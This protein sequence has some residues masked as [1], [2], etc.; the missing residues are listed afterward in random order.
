M[1]YTN[2]TVCIIPLKLVQTADNKNT[3]YTSTSNGTGHHNTRVHFFG[4]VHFISERGKKPTIFP[5]CNTVAFPYLYCRN[6]NNHLTLKWN[7]PSQCTVHL[8]W[9]SSFHRRGGSNFYF[10]RDYESFTRHHNLIPKLFT[11]HKI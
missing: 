5:E 2:N 10:G 7:V 9:D 3:R 1:M 8:F 11:Q 4:L 6:H